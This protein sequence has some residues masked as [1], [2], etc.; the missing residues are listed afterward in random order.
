M[1]DFAYSIE[2]GSFSMPRYDLRKSERLISKAILY[3]LT[4]SLCFIGCNKSMGPPEP[5][6]FDGFDMLVRGN[7][8]PGRLENVSINTSVQVADE[9]VKGVAFLSPT[10]V[11]AV[12]ESGVIISYKIETH[13]TTTIAN[14]GKNLKVNWRIKARNHNDFVAIKG[15]DIYSSALQ[16]T[17]LNRNGSIYWSSPNNPEDISYWVSTGGD[18]YGTC[19][20][21]KDKLQL[22]SVNG[23]GDLRMLREFQEDMDSLY[24]HLPIEQGILFFGLQSGP[25]LL[26]KSTNYTTMGLWHLGWD[27]GFVHP[28]YDQKSR[29]CGCR[30]NWETEGTRRQSEL[31]ILDRALPEPVVVPFTRILGLEEYDVMNPPKPD[32]Y[33]VASNGNTV[34]IE[35]SHY[36]L[37][38]DDGELKIWFDNLNDYKESGDDA[39]WG[40]P[41]FIDSGCEHFLMKTNSKLLYGGSTI[42]T[43][44]FHG[45]SYSDI[46]FSGGFERAAIGIEE[47][48]IMIFDLVL[49]GIS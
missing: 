39:L 2:K 13:E 8:L 42:K 47:G 23:S 43:I 7:C 20:N 22:W 34:A 45:L 14:L 29:L 1:I 5:V 40:G 33:N 27:S 37:T 21:S 28:V 15:P 48:S 19:D 16:I 41:I 31:V 24:F 11:I 46:V 12:T 18:Y 10:E 36:I 30:E 26:D 44:D 49:T 38:Y 3:I 35:Y 6:C 17:A 32:N 4:L 9:P 25:Y